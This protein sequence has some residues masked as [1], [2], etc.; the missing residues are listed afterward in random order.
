MAPVLTR[1]LPAR[2]NME[3]AAL[4]GKH[5]AQFYG[6]CIHPLLAS[7]TQHGEGGSPGKYLARVHGTCYYLPSAAGHNVEEETLW[8]KHLSHA[9]PL[10]SCPPSKI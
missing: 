4:Q 9:V 3:K 10:L 5:L 7:W 8:G 6:T 2:H 1:F